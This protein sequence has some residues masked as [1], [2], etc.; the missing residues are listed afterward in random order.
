[1]LLI[2]LSVSWGASGFSPA[3]EDFARDAG[4]SGQVAT[5]GLSMYV[6][7]LSLG[8]MTLA[9]LSE[10]FGRSPVYIG[11]YFVY[12]CLLLATATA[13]AT[14]LGFLPLRFLSG[15]F[16]S[17]TIANFGGSI[18]DLF[19]THDTGPAMSLYMWAATAGSPT[20]FLAMSFVAQ[21]GG[22]RDVFWAL[23]GV[24]SSFWV[25]MTV[26]L[27]IAGETRH[28]VILARRRKAGPHGS[29]AE[30]EAVAAAARTK[31]DAAQRRKASIRQ[32][33]TVSLGRPFRFL[34]TEAII[35]FG[36]VYNGYLYGLSFLFNSAFSLIF[37]R[38]G[39]GFD[40]VGVGLCFLGIT[41]GISLG[42]FT[43]I[44]QERYYQRRMGET[45]GRNCPEARVQLAKVAAVGKHLPTHPAMEEKGNKKRSQRSQRKLLCIR[46]Y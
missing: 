46:G 21:R 13:P 2:D 17:V 43:N 32:F 44:W 39:H 7:G 15:L 1:M 37:G 23:L 19:H 10:S 45:G 40:S 11:S 35:M 38:A 9:P 16:S 30:E 6:L 18:A 27:L 42:P 25:L 20:G 14:L 28:S 33:F 5:L 3:E 36:A 4:V 34:G 31:P 22:W 41:I 12:L 26:G 24:C 29:A 8:P